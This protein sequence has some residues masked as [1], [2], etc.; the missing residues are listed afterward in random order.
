[1]DSL[2]GLIYSEQFLKIQVIYILV[3]KHIPNTSDRRQARVTNQCI[4]SSKKKA[5]P[6]LSLIDNLCLLARYH[7]YIYRVHT[8]PTQL[9]RNGLQTLVT[10]V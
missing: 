2:I 4:K 8:P 10:R 3:P 9:L 7:I 5:V 1:V 6:H